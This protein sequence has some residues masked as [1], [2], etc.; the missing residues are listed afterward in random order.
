[1]RGLDSELQRQIWNESWRQLIPS[2]RRLEKSDYKDE[3]QEQSGEKSL[4]GGS[5]RLLRQLHNEYS[6]DFIQ[7]VSVNTAIREYY[8]KH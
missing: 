2:E 4:Y 1:M 7:G 8:Y 6:E 5:V 3:W